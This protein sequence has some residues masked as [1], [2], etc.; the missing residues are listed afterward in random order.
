MNTKSVY[1]DYPGYSLSVTLTDFSLYIFTAIYVR[2]KT[3]RCNPI[4]MR[5]TV[6]LF[7]CLGAYEVL[8]QL[9]YPSQ[10]A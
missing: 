3:S 8:W 6:F 1:H 7:I 4:Q 5:M 2:S 10:A 9:Y